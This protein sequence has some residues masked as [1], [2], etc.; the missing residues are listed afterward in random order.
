MSV[1]SRAVVADPGGPLWTGETD[2]G[3]VDLNDVSFC[4]GRLVLHALDTATA[5]DL[6]Q[7]LQPYTH[8]IRN[9]VVQDRFK[10][11][12]EVSPEPLDWSACA[13]VEERTTFFLSPWHIDN[14]FHVHG[15]NL[16]A[17]FANLRHAGALDQSRLL[18]LY[19]GDSARNA[20]A[21]QLWAIMDA[22]FDGAVRP[23]RELRNSKERVG[24]RHVRWGRGP[25][26]F[27]LKESRADTFDDVPGEYRRWVLEHFGIA[28]RLN[29]Q[30]RD[31][32]PRVLMLPRSDS[33]RI[34]NDEL[35]AQALSDLGLDVRVFND[36]S[37]ISAS[38]LV[39]MAHDADVLI[40]VHGAGLTHMAY[41]PPGSLV[42][43]LLSGSL[44]D[45]PVYR[46]LASKFGHRHVTIDVAGAASAEPTHIT[47]VGAA[48]VAQRVLDEWNGRLRRRAI[49]VRNL[50]TGNWG[51]EVFW[52][53]FGKTYARRHDLTLQTGPWTGNVLVGA[54]DPPIQQQFED[55]HE[56][57][58]HGV[59]DT[60]IPNAPPLGDVNFVGYFQYHTSYY[61]ADRDYIRSLFQPDP[62]VEARIR[63]GWQRLRGRGRTAVGIHIRRNDYGMRYFY[64]TPIQWYLD[65]LERI[66]P[67]LD[68]PFLYVASDAIDEVIG[69]FAKY[70]PAIAADLGPPLAS[71]DFYRD[72][73]VL[74]HCDVLMIPNST[75]S[76]TAGMLNAGL[77]GAYRS[78]LSSRGFVPFDPWNSKPLDQDWESFVERYP[79]YE[80]LWK[81]T[82]AAT[83]WKRWGRHHLRRR[84]RG[85]QRALMEPPIWTL[86]VGLTREFYRRWAVRRRLKAT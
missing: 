76:F 21:V 86:P 55:F 28:P 70:Q 66:W 26:V 82:P 78:Q 42:V 4:H 12:F 31:E 9:F 8:F 73:Y 32:P 17:M 43:E 72:F 33:R 44:R 61:A 23:I 39:T 34:A 57:E 64:R 49:T 3:L 52:Y 38:A 59:D 13:R 18:Y 47:A 85:L 7:Q 80:E 48:G 46:H 41:M 2:P 79:W 20:Q 63:P 1:R 15:D 62:A 83:R 50:G 74:Q 58:E 16:V 54:S 45:V 81:P 19:E 22:L 56:K 53:M 11:V 30:R 68:R 14:A 77:Q 6:P 24:F 10:D 84:V 5:R 29:D 75:F 35:I 67:T 27:Y 65:H 69:A 36:W 40:G 60:V 37:R 71:H 25:R 51:N